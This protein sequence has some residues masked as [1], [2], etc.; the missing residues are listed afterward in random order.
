MNQKFTY[1]QFLSRFP[2][3]ESCLEE[4]KKLRYPYGVFCKVCEIMAKHYKLKGRTAY[5][6]KE[7]RNQ[8]FPL[9][10][11]ILEKTTTPLKTWFLAMFLMTHTRS[12]MTIK[13]LQWELGVTYKTAWRIHRNIMLLME[14][15][16]GDLLREVNEVDIIRQH[17]SIHRWTFFSKLEITL[18]QK[19]EESSD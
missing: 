15:N 7:C 14:Q 19:Q 16:G 9:S 4:F 5:S 8:V 18:T 6:C 1:S 13:Q 2:T 11:T 17:Q 10:G 12:R 3:E